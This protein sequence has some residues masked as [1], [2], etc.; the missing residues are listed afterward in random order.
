MNFQFREQYLQV[1]VNSNNAI[2]SPKNRVQPLNCQC[3]RVASYQVIHAL[4][5]GRNYEVVGSYLSDA[6]CEIVQELLKNILNSANLDA[7]TRFSCLQVL[8]R[9]DVRKLDTGIFPHSYYE[10]L[11]KVITENGTG[12]RYLNLKGV[13]VRDHP[14]LLALLIRSLGKLKVLVIPHMADDQVLEAIAT[15]SSLNA[16]DISGEC[17]FT[18]SGLKKLELQQLQMLDIG[19][20]GKSDICLGENGCEIVAE[21]IETLPN[22]CYLKTYSFTGSSLLLLY[23]KRQTKFKTKLKYLHDTFTTVDV[24]KAIV[25]LCPNLES[26]HLDTPERG[27][28]GEFSNLKKLNCIKLVKYDGEDLTNYLKTSRNNLQILKLNHNK[29]YTLDLSDLCLLVPDLHTLECFQAKLSF[30]QLENYFMNLE[31]VEILYCEVSDTT[32]RLLLTNTPFLK[33]IV[34][35][36]V[37]NMTDGDIFRLCA[38]CD[39]VCLEELWFSCAKGLTSIS[40]ELLMGHCPNLRM[41]GQLNGW[42][43]HQEEVDYLRS[44]LLYTNT[45]LTLLPLGVFP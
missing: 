35:G 8:L 39:F 13:W 30:L 33:R 1:L 21:L 32:L 4:S 15:C 11:L 17:S 45:D 10:A 22:L 36:C 29:N 14:D 25:E 38:E 42:D 5:E 19:Y 26:L 37:I 34:I 24:M 27:V 40:V 6:T 3:I 44:V 20:F 43:V 7:A 12:L 28:I 9:Q 41:I 31:N 23:R 16:L 18:N 2:M